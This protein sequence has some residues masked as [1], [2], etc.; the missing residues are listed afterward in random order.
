MPRLYIGPLPPRKHI[1]HIE[2]TA[3]ENIFYYAAPDSTPLA[4][5]AALKTW[6][7]SRIPPGLPST[8]RGRDNRFIRA[9]ACRGLRGLPYAAAAAAAVMTIFYKNEIEKQSLN[10]NK[11]KPTFARMNKKEKNTYFRIIPFERNAL[12]LYAEYNFYRF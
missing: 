8:R 12:Y 9:R 3:H 5:G 6:R 10:K 11:K 7:S 1:I 2:D 4:V